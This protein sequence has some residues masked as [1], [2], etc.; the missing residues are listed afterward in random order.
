MEGTD[1]NP[2]FVTRLQQ[3]ALVPIAEPMDMLTTVLTTIL[4]VT[5][6]FAW[7]HVMQHITED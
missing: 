7:V 2:G 3:W 4:I 6:A 5:L 1:Q